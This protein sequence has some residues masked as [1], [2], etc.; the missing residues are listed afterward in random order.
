M[1]RKLNYGADFDLDYDDYSDYDE[2]YNEDPDVEEEDGI[3]SFQTDVDTRTGLWRCSIC[4]FDNAEEFS[5][6]DVCG[7]EKAIENDKGP[8]IGLWQCSICTFDNAENTL[9]CEICGVL[10][11][12]PVKVSS[13][14]SK[15]TDSAK[16]SSS[17]EGPHNTLGKKEN[18]DS[19]PS[20]KELEDLSI[21]LEKVGQPSNSDTACSSSSENMM[22]RQ[23]LGINS[24]SSNDIVKIERATAGINSESSNDNVKIERATARPQY[25][26]E[27]W[28]H[29][30]QEGALAQLNLAIVG[31]VDAGKSTLS[32]RLLNLLGKISQKEMRKF[33]KDAKSS[34]KGSFA[35]AWAMDESAEERERGVTMN[36]A[37]A[38]FDS[39]KY[40]VVVLD[41]PG[42]RDFIPNLINGANQADA[43]ILVIDASFGPF[44][45]GMDPNGGQTREHAQLI[46]S[47]GVDQLIVAINKMDGADYSKERFDFIKGKLSTFLRGC[48][49][50]DSFLIWV[51]LS[52]MEN[53][54]LVT[55]PSD[56]RLSS[57]Y[58]GPSLLEAIDSIQPPL[59]DISKPLVMPI[60]ELIKP[61]SVGQ[62]A[63]CGKL[64]SGAIKCGLKV[65]VMPY[66]DIATIRTLERDSQPCDIARAG[67]NV[68]VSLQGVDVTHVLAGGVLCHPDFPVAVAT[69]LELKILMLDVS[70]P[71]IL[72]SQMEFHIHHCKEAVRISKILSLLDPKTGKVL[73]KSPRVLTS[74]Q[75]ALIE[76]IVENAVCV[77]EF[78]NCRALGRVFLR[79][80]GK[81]AAV[82]IVT[83][84]IN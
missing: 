36:V 77:E 13:N 62:I 46:R 48:G 37:V 11:Y 1:P 82:G 54:N 8:K 50:R 34:G 18:L 30:N 15:A 71:I 2:D 70:M 4:T 81:T 16:V 44:E 59:R 73:R 45:T 22:H 64:E 65:L 57:W 12:P 35:Y 49:F 55:R 21:Q 32:G 66:G 40:H 39:N 69:H 19:S 79:A 63:A 42:H 83:R 6:C 17:I 52:A 56:I 74:K 41:S 84:V 75:S 7:T 23:N 53:Q 47:F 58:K 14:G 25:K 20:P 26:P 24:E 38:Y 27:K 68:V 29:A 78:S 72:G 43:A 3:E 61:R 31:H 10:R 80:Y 5:A 60:C 28:M 76:V 51:P 9:S 33:E 67:D